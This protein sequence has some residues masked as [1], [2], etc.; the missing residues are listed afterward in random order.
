[1]VM[2]LFEELEKTNKGD[3]I[4]FKKLFVLI[5]LLFQENKTNKTAGKIALDDLLSTDETILINAERKIVED[6]WKG[7]FTKFTECWA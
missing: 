3:A 5:G 7:M 6:P 2:K 4:L 1:M